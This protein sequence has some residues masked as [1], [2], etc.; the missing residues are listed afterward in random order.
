MSAR[1]HDGR[2][3]RILN[4]IDESTRECL[5]IRAERRWSSAKVIGALADVMV[6]KGVPEH[7]R[8]DNGPEFVAKDLRQ[9]LTDTGAK[10]LYIEPGSPL[11]ERLLRKLQLQAQRRVP[12]RRTLLL[13]ERTT[14]AGRTL[15]Q[16]LQH[17]QTTLLAGIQTSST[18]GM[19]D[20]NHSA[21][22]GA[23]R[24]APGSP[25]SHTLHRS[26]LRGQC[27]TLTPHWYKSS[28]NPLD[29]ASAS[30]ISTRGRR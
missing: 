23:S 19:D 8:S 22:W 25:C 18:R 5:L 7:L 3:V 12:Q 2:S 10:T 29:G 17:R 26:E 27:A 30:I 11:G 21:A 13:D 20:F 15:A 1:T 28:G 6:L 24:F 14:C 4:L 9:W 16:A